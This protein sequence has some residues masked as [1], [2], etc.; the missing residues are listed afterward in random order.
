MK[1]AVLGGG[2]M[3]GAIA[4]G[5]VEHG[6]VAAADMKISHPSNPI[7]SQFEAGGYAVSFT[8]DNTEATEGADIVIVAVKPWIA[9]EV[10]NQ[11][12]PVLRLGQ[13]VVSIVSGV[14]LATLAEWIGNTAQPLFRVIPNTAISLGLSTTFICHQHA[15]GTQR[16]AI[17]SLFEP[18]GT[19]FFVE[20]AQ[21]SA[22]TSLSSCGIAYAFKYI[23]AATKGGVELG[24]APA[25]SLRIVIQTM[26][27]ALAMLDAN[28][29]APQTEIDKV[30]TPGGITLQGLAAMEQNGFTKA[31]IEGLKASR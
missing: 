23:D 20:E 21:M 8:T 31:V 30:T 27:G 3:G 12:A 14:T 9:Q 15:D 5:A 2:N 19:L 24:I 11:I 10:C 1:I 29:T 25:E 13:L 17:R 7:R 4:F 26:K 6:V 16:D 28:H 22:V 18:L